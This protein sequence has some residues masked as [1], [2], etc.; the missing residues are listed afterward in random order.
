MWDAGS[1]RMCFDLGPGERELGTRSFAYLTRKCRPVLFSTGLSSGNVW[2]TERTSP[3]CE[4]AEN[5]WR[6]IAPD[7]DGR[8]EPTTTPPSVADAVTPHLSFGASD[9][10]PP[11]ICSCTT[12]KSCGVPGKCLRVSQS[13]PAVLLYVGW[14]TVIGNSFCTTWAGVACLLLGQGT[15]NGER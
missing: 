4:V 1:C 2:F 6:F 13:S 14:R 10:P 3:T 12:P 7:P 9:V 11:L 15:C 8:A 5:S